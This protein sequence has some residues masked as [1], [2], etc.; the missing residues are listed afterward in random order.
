MKNR[1]IFLMLLLIFSLVIFTATACS[2]ND[3]PNVPDTV[4]ENNGNGGMDNTDNN[5]MDNNNN[6]M[7][8]N[9]GNGGIS[10]PGGVTNNTNQ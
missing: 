8:N 2:T 5:G 7:G 3:T 4:D 10:S 9:N 6:G 1:K